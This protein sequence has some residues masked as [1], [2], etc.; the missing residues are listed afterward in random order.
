MLKDEEKTREQLLEELKTERQKSQELLVFKEKSTTLEKQL[1]EQKTTFQALF[2]RTNDAI[3]LIGLD[4]KFFKVNKRAG[5][6]LGLP[7][8]EIYL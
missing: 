3:F 2:E 1:E 4:N 7:V 8:E 6:L 5:E